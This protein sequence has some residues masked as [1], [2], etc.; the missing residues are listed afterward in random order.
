M[1]QRKILYIFIFSGIL[2]CFGA[3]LVRDG[4]P[5]SEIVIAEHAGD[6]VRLAA[7]DLQTYLQKISGAKL[8]IVVPGNAKA[9]NLICVG[10]SRCTRQAGYKMP[11]FSGS[12]YDIWAK[13]NLVVLSGPEK[14]HKKNFFFHEKSL[15]PQNRLKILSSE[16]PFSEDDCG[17]HHAVSAFL[18]FLGVR[19]YAPYEN[20]TVVPR[21][22]TISIPDF[23]ETKEAAFSRRVYSYGVDPQL[24][25]EGAMWFKRLKCGSSLDSI[26]V[27]PLAAV[28]L[29]KNPPADWTALDKQGKPVPTLEGCIFPRLNHPGFRQECVRSIRQILDA[30]PEMKQLLLVLPISRGRGDAQE[31]A[32]LEKKTTFP[33]PPA[34]VDLM[35]DFFLF[36]AGEVGKTHPDRR[37]LCQGFGGNTLPSAKYRESMPENL[38]VHPHSYSSLFYAN[39]KKREGYLKQ[40]GRLA[41]LSSGKMQQQEWWNEFSSPDTP[42]QGAWFMHGLQAVRREQRAL[43]SGFRMEAAADSA[44]KRLAEVPLTHLMYY[45]NSKLMWDPGLNLEELLNEYYRLWFG[46]AAADMKSFFQ[47]AESVVSRPGTRSIMVQKGRL[48][49]EDVSVGFELLARAKARTV[50]GTL[51]FH[52]IEAL[53]Q[54]FAPLKTIFQKRIP[55]GK[56]L[57][58]KILPFDVKSDGSFS[59]YSNWTVIP[60]SRQ[61]CRTEFA[62][63]VTE[64][65][66]RMLVAFR[67]WEPE[68]K[69][70]KMASRNQDDPA[71]FRDDHIRIDFHT[72]N[73][74]GFT[75]AVNPAG[76]LL[77]WST[78]PEYVCRQGCASGWNPEY[79]SV[80]VKRCPDRWEGEVVIDIPSAGKAPDFGDAWGF[81]FTRVR[82]CGG[83][84]E[85]SALVP[86][87]EKQPEKLCRFVLPKVDSKGRPVSQYYSANILL[88]GYPDESVYTVK[89]AVG[90]VDLAAPW[91][92]KCW[93]NI[94]EMRLGWEGVS[95][96]S[97]GFRPD[98]RAKIQYDDQYLYVLYQVHDQYVRATFKQD[99]DMV[100]LD[101]CMEIF[102][103]PDKKGPYYNFECNCIGTLLLYEISP[104]QTTIM[105]PEEMKEIKR[106][107]TLP[108]SLNGEITKPVVW[109]LGLRI[110][111]SLFVR[112]AG[113]QLPLS[114]QVWSGNVYKCA[115]WSSHPCWLSWKNSSTFHAPDEFGKLIFE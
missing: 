22:K 83:K 72:Q 45:V 89:R 111:L 10:E 114:G 28:L 5:C 90:P 69:R 34:H 26:G 82:T 104:L 65:R 86:D 79:S 59:K 98:A 56:V 52:R 15:H 14:V 4:K 61:E 108:R 92:G 100:C 63:A 113:V 95:A 97:S 54:A 1:H 35:A 60:G 93:G 99:Q 47:Y 9:K 94:R 73:R 7:R 76:N 13:G 17:P 112:R 46:P 96:R 55:Q 88:P 41:S 49:P 6:G 102:L 38:Q 31:L 58:G 42:R 75:V 8:P 101:S 103:Q 74:T 64:N 91:D 30:N 25:P 11:V 81:N 115:D 84:P 43:V 18:E 12:G 2:S 57:T 53:E 110:P 67:C 29:H 50:P 68:M 66:G 32:A 23:R 27:L 39:R 77:D 107:S 85:V 44:R 109:R 105:P 24:D 51:F 106:F 36:L 70:L 48:T 71:L 62:L 20:G 37:L 40:I 33:I 78:D 80:S 3:D 21:R 16:F 19:F 87:A